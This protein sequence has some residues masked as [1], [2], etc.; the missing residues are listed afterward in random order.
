MIAPDTEWR[1]LLL[2]PDCHGNHAAVQAEIDNRQRQQ[3]ADYCA[4]LDRSVLTDEW[5]DVKEMRGNPERKSWCRDVEEGS[6]NRAL[7]RSDARDDRVTDNCS[8]T[9]GRTEKQDRSK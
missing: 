9:G 7:L 6:Y 8:Y 1:D 5:R 3:R 2:K 4:D